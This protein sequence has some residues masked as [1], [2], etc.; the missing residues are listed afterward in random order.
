M[1][2]EQFHGAVQILNDHAGHFELDADRL[3][4]TEI[5]IRLSSSDPYR[6]LGA[7]PTP[8]GAISRVVERIHKLSDELRSIGL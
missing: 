8:K 7:L 4:G 1:T 2:D 5:E 3:S 6:S